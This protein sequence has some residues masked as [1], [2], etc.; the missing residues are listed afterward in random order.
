[1]FAF[2]S[3]A[4]ISR[5]SKLRD[6]LVWRTPTP[7]PL[8]IDLVPDFFAVVDADDPVA[9][10][11][12]Y[13]RANERLLRAYWQNYVF[14]PEGEDFQDVVRSTIAADRTDLRNMVAR[15]DVIAIARH[16]EERC[17]ELLAIDVD[18]DLVL[19]V[20]VGAANAGELVIDGRGV[21]FACLEHFTGIAN[22]ATHGLGLDPEL[23]SLWLAHEITHAV[24]YT[25][26]TSRSEMKELVAGAAGNYSYWDTARQA[27]LRELLANEGLAVQASRL[28]C[29]G[30]AAWEYFGYTRRDFARVR[31]LERII[32]R[33]ASADLDRSALGLR[34]RYLSGGMSETARTVDRTVLPERAGYFLG[35]RMVEPAIEQHGLAWAARASA[36]ELTAVALGTAQSA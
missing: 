17:R 9:A 33:A 5:D 12:A 35:A 3:G 11:G 32:A 7:S 15:N 1:M 6:R 34:L 18:F 2:T 14:D 20:G 27:T 4:I 29:P 31:E 26:P 23:L 25:S 8:L 10:Y 24:R 21:A 30:H 28:A 16:A 36:D 19:M 13:F 22:P